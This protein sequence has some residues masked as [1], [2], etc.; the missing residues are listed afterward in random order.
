MERKEFCFLRS[1]LI[2]IFFQDPLES[3]F[4]IPGQ[5]MSFMKVGS[6]EDRHLPKEH[7]LQLHY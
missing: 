4:K 5:A 1:H 3:K 7:L 2:Y 6:R